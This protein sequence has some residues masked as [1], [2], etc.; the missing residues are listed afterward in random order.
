MSLN[1]CCTARGSAQ[2]FAR[3]VADW[4]LPPLFPVPHSADQLAS[5]GMARCCTAAIAELSLHLATASPD[6]AL[7]DQKRCH[8]ARNI[9][10]LA[11]YAAVQ[12]YD[13]GGRP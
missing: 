10:D 1:M 13:S 4:V 3:F 8:L 12:A 2:F 7:S 9:S 6:L 11:K 5:S